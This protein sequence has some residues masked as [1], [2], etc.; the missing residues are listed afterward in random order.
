MLLTEGKRFV[1]FFDLLGFGA[2]VESSG[3]KEVFTYVRGFLNLMVRSSLPGSVVHEDMSVDIE[4]SNIG[5]INFSD[6]VVF[7]SRDDSYDCLKTMLF[8]CGEFMNIVICGP[9]RMLRG[10][11]A[12]GEFYVDPEVNAYVGQALID[13]YRLE[14]RQD[15]LGLSL[16]ESVERLPDFNRALDDHKGFIVRS[17]VPLLKS[18]DKPYCINWANKKFIDASFNALRG[19]EDSYRRGLKALQGNPKEL[20]KLKR[21]YKSTKEFLIHYNEKDRVD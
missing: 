3:S 8:V 7:Y 16:H 12:R 19:L 6:S 5:Y 10:A 13:A 17:L 21:R 15:W 18:E 1:A 14:E 2:W 9:S 11:I 20:D 4:E